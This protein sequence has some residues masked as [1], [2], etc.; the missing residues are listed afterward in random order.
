[1]TTSVC[2]AQLSVWIVNVV[3]LRVILFPT[4][5]NRATAPALDATHSVTNAPTRLVRQSHLTQMHMHVA[6]DAYSY[7]GL[8]QCSVLDLHTDH[9]AMSNFLAYLVVVH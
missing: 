8:R 4:F 9:C 5:I 3:C 1:M 6:P 7:A 2:R